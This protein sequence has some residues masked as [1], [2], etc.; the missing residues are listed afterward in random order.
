MDYSVNRDTQV[1]SIPHNKP[2][3]YKAM[4][5]NIMCKCDYINEGYVNLQ[6]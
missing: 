5:N 4:D 1:A 3:L 2:E 6:S